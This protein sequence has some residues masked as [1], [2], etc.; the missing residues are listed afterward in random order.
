MRYKSKETMAN[1]S[2]K[3]PA[4]LWDSNPCRPI[5]KGSK[6]T[7]QYTDMCVCALYLCPLHV[8]IWWGGG[9][10]VGGHTCSL[11]WWLLLTN[12]V[13]QTVYQTRMMHTSSSSLNGASWAACTH[14]HTH[15]HTCN[16]ARAHQFGIIEPR[17]CLNKLTYT[18]ILDQF[19]STLIA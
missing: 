2:P 12:E 5:R 14:T 1:T 15:T 17:P 3:F 8:C 19:N 4:R 9:M 11:L 18:R 13:T 10:W 7:I 6:S 16:L